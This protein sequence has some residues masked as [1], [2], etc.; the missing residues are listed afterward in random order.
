[1]DSSPYTCFIFIYE[2]FVPSI[3]QKPLWFWLLFLPTVWMQ[4][5]TVNPNDRSHSKSIWCL[6]TPEHCSPCALGFTDEPQGWPWE[7]A[8]GH[9]IQTQFLWVSQTNLY[10]ENVQHS[11][12]NSIVFSLSFK[13]KK[14]RCSGNVSLG[15]IL[16]VIAVR[17]H[18]QIQSNKKYRIFI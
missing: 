8:S 2:P 13:E 9:V 16:G 17:G 5:E 15:F 10:I 6:Q 4:P 12:P 11:W 7:E 14:K 1:M 18:H 3:L